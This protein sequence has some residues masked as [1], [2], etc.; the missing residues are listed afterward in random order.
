MKKRKSTDISNALTGV[1]I[2]LV[3]VM[4]VGFLFVFTNNFTSPLR[5][6]YVSY[7]NDDIITDRDNF[8]IEL[9]KEYKFKVHTHFKLEDK[10]SRYIVTLTPNPSHDFTFQANE[11]EIQYSSLETLSKGF[12]IDTFSDY[13]NFTAHFDLPQILQM[14]YPSQTLKD[15][16]SAVDSGIPYFTLTVH[17]HD[18]SECININFSLL[19]SANTINEVYSLVLSPV[20]DTYDIDTN[21]FIENAVTFSANQ[22]VLSKDCTSIIFEFYLKD[23]YAFEEVVCLF[24]CYTL[25]IDEENGTCTVSL[26]EELTSNLDYVLNFIAYKKDPYA[27]T[28]T[29][30]NASEYVNAITFSVENIQVSTPYGTSFD[31]YLADGYKVETL[32]YSKNG[33][34]VKI[35]GDKNT[36]TVGLERKLVEDVSYNLEFFPYPSGN[37]PSQTY[38][39]TLNFLDCSNQRDDTIPQNVITFSTNSIDL[40]STNPSV[41]INFEIAESFIFEEVVGN[42]D[43]YSVSVDNENNTFTITLTTTLTNNLNEQLKFYACKNTVEPEEYTLTISLV[44]E[45]SAIT[46]SVE[47]IVLTNNSTSATFIVYFN[48]CEFGGCSYPSGYYNVSDSNI[49]PTESITYTISLTQP[50]TESLNHVFNVFILLN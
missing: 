38:A 15:V 3:V 50:L 12:E 10:Q 49:N 13:F 20:N 7:G 14:Y 33:Y 37:T 43:K 23:G 11:E 44:G 28:L 4:V 17:N 36:C 18:K 21:E 30:V 27:I 2:F 41:T 1:V 26:T 47:E 6:F 46:F 24:D 5:N 32:S 19:S 16:P 48:D 25:E 22:I 42:Y 34:W 9:G 35:D 40:S 8:E 39:L 45:T 29:P 31:F